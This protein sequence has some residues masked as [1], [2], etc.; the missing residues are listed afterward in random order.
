MLKRT[1]DRSQSSSSLR[2]LLIIAAL[3][4]VAALAVGTARRRVEH[5]EGDAVHDDGGL[6]RS[7][8]FQAD[9]AAL[10]ERLGDASVLAQVLEP[11]VEVEAAGGDH[12]TWRLALPGGHSFDWT[13]QLAGAGGSGPLAW[14]STD[15]TGL[16]SVAEIDFRP[17]T[18][19][20][21][22]VVTLRLEFAPPLG[23]LGR[24]A[25]GLFAKP[26]RLAAMG[27]L[28]RLRAL[29]QTGEVPAT[30]PNPAAR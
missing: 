9:A 3:A 5:G 8:T 15:G 22:T 30:G 25:V 18:G 29:V 12:S 4:G 23:A 24:A 14:R 28:Y 13:M 11:A 16:P 2:P 27:T 21:G 17:A 6:R 1:P 7:L 26:I 19:G 20:R 10:R